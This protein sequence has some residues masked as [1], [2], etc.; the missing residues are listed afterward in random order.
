MRASWR[1]VNSTFSLLSGKQ[2]PPPP[3]FL[4]LLSVE[5][6]GHRSSREKKTVLFQRSN[7]PSGKFSPSHARRNRLFR[8]SFRDFDVIFLQRV[9]FQKCQDFFCFSSEWNFKS[10]KISFVSSMSEI[11]KVSRFLLFLQR[12]KFQKYQDFFCFSSEWNSKSIKISFVSSMSEIP[13]VSRF[14]LFLQWV[15]FQKYQD[16]FCFW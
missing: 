16:F 8:K 2:R 11:S 4:S 6:V 7:H 14:L 10:I 9:K 1:T 5:N 3:L 15:K 13:K 12:V